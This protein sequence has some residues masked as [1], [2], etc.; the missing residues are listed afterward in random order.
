M[1]FSC[2]RHSETKN[3]SQGSHKTTNQD[4]DHCPRSDAIWIATAY[5]AWTFGGV[6]EILDIS[7]IYSTRV[8]TSW[9]VINRTD[10]PW[11]VISRVETPWFVI[12]R[13]ETPWFVIFRVETRWFIISTIIAISNTRVETP[14]FVIFRVK[15]PWFIIIIISTIVAISNTRS[16][17]DIVFF[18]WFFSIHEQSKWQQH[19]PKQ[20]CE[21]PNVK[22]NIEIKTKYSCEWRNSNSDTSSKL[23]GFTTRSLGYNSL[24]MFRWCQSTN[25]RKSRNVQGIWI[26]IQRCGNRDSTIYVSDCPTRDHVSVWWNRH[27]TG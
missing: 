10:T 6:F 23:L 9:F 3:N 1:V 17:P 12:T 18:Q 13:T 14:W 2:T 15:T 7:I 8:E 4:K 25:R 19:K 27:C 5:V 24:H 20:L 11:F 22:V 16:S 26:W 21:P